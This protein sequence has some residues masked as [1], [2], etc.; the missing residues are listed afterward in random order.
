MRKKIYVILLCITFFTASFITVQASNVTKSSI[1]QYSDAFDERGLGPIP[2]DMENDKLPERNRLVSSVEISHHEFKPV[3][4]DNNIVTLIQ[5]LD[6]DLILDYLEDITAFGPRVTGTT[7]C[8]Q[9]GEYIYNEFVNL[10]LEVR[11]HPWG[12]N[13]LSGKN[14]EATIYGIDDS[15]DEIYIVCAHYD[16]VPGS[17]GADDDGSGVAAVMASAKLMSSYMTNYTVRFVTFSGEEQGLH[18]SYHYVQEAVQNNDNIVA[19][20]NVDMIGYAETTQ[21]ANYVKIFEDEESE[22]LTDFTTDVSQQYND[23]IGI[24]VIPSGYSWGSDHY[25]FWQAGYNAIFYHEYNFNNYYHS[26]GDTIEH[27]D[28]TYA[29]KNSKLIFATLAELSD[30]NMQQSPNKPSKPAGENSGRYGEEYVYSAV[31]TDPQ[32][33]QILY[34]FD[35]GDGTDSGWIGPFDSGETGEASHVW[36]QRGTYSIKVKAKDIEGHESAWSNSLVVSMP[37]TKI[38][39]YFS[40]GFSRFFNL[41]DKL[42]LFL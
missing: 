40:N 34:L 11:Y 26:S 27:M 42:I 15:S 41:L 22:W 33:D 38:I 2:G 6:E 37:K 32:N 12:N 20:L 36:M 23:L 29:A 28:L 39:N 24:Q 10:G 7:A 31:T 21:D 8:E 19:V 1:K 18:G 3:T 4:I 17:P 16:S 13:G 5:Q 25:Y 30:L 35:W 14:I 9:A